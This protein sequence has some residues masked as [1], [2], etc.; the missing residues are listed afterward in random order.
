MAQIVEGSQ[1]AKSRWR[2]AF[3]FFVELNALRSDQFVKGSLHQASKVLVDCVR[4]VSH[5]VVLEAV[6]RR[7]LAKASEE[8]GPSQV[9]NTMLELL[10]C[11]TGNLCVEMICDLICKTTFNWERF[12]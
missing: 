6:E 12:I 1:I 11:T 3:I 10:E 2:Q 7:I 9:V 5:D 8:V 4:N